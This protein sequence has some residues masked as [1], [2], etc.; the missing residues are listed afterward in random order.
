[1]EKGEIKQIGYEPAPPKS[2]SLFGLN[3]IL[4]ASPIDVPKYD[5]GERFD[6]RLPYAEVFVRICFFYLNVFPIKKDHLFRP[7]HVHFQL[8]Y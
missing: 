7:S 1:M 5:E 3:I 4:P 8:M 2:S 6:L